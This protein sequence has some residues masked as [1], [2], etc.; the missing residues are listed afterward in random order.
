MKAFS[1]AELDKQMRVFAER[2][3]EK[4]TDCKNLEQIQYYISELCLKIREF[5]SRFQYVPETAYLLLNQY[6]MRQN[7]FVSER[8][9]MRQYV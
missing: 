9:R 3:F 7:A 4:P 2:N 6:N 8:F 5:E 1:K